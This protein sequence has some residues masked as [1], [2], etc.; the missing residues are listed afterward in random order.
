MK[1]WAGLYLVL[2]LN[3]TYSQ[4][5]TADFN[6][7]DGRAV[8]IEAETPE[9]LSYKLTNHY[10]TDLEKVRAIFRWI[11]EN[12]SY[13][14]RSPY[15][16]LINSKRVIVEEPEDTSSILKPLNERVAEIVLRK[17][18][19]VCDGYARLFKIL[20]DYAGVRSAIISGFARYSG[21]GASA[22][23]RS[24]HT[25][26]AVFLDSSWHLL[27]ATWASG[28]T[29]Y[30]GTEFIRRYD[31]RYFLASPQS[32]I[33]DHY[34]DDPKWTLLSTPPTLNE[35]NHTPFKYLGF[36]KFKIVSFQPSKGIV[37]ASVGDTIRFELETNELK[38]NLFVSPT[39]YG[40]SSIYYIYGDPFFP[41][42]TGIQ[43]GKKISYTYTVTPYETGWLH[44]VFND[45]LLFR[46]KLN[47]KKKSD[48]ALSDQ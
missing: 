3:P 41:E 16:S 44:V 31:D 36:V 2:F 10:K 35:F 33:Y 25:W 11:T 47:I 5:R 14:V 30:N 46:Y 4:R 1:W 26:N 9:S 39:P 19:A 27:D 13:N 42:T 28:Y 23:F 48:V 37:E 15:R 12:I 34:P 29:N 22:R 45:E 43:T 17:R 32:F 20:C 38:R 40:D 24:N 8:S 7:I 6:S 21:G 18:T